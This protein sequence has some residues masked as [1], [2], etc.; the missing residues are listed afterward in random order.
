VGVKSFAFLAKSLR[1][2]PEKW[3]GL[4]DVETR[5]GSATST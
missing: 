1:P 3:H 4:K 2:L 5:Y